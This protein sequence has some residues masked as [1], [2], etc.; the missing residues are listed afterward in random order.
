M[1]C[2]EPPPRGWPPAPSARA[3]LYAVQPRSPPRRPHAETCGRCC[4][5]L[6]V[7]E[8]G[9]GANSAKG[10][11]CAA[12]TKWHSS[13]RACRSCAVARQVSPRGSTAPAAPT[14]H[15][16]DHSDSRRPP[17][18]KSDG[19]PP[20]TSLFAITVNPVAGGSCH[21]AQRHQL[22][23]QALSVEKPSSIIAG[24]PYQ[25]LHGTLTG[26]R[27]SGRITAMT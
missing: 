23:G 25:C 24:W 4:R 22:L 11:G 7:A 27:R 14:P 1:G 6:S 5:P 8:S 17:A 13:P 9:R 15:R 12:N 18:D 16:S 2:R 21:P 26:T 19:A 20:S 3:T 10:C